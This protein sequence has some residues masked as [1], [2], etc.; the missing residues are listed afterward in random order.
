MAPLE[1]T[2]IAG[3]PAACPPPPFPPAARERAQARSSG[4]EVV[5]N[6]LCQRRRRDFHAFCV[7]SFWAGSGFVFKNL[8]VTLIFCTL[9]ASQLF[10]FSFFFS[11]LLYLI[12][13][14]SPSIPTPH[15]PHRAR[16]VT[17]LCSQA[18]LT[19]DKIS[20]RE[21]PHA[22]HSDRRWQKSP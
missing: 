9:S 18:Q 21:R 3:M 13:A 4:A 12:W 15:A 2:S 7:H 6:A 17:E 10:F 1:K 5:E 11:R 8:L 14:W 20:A 22:L 16:A 19:Q